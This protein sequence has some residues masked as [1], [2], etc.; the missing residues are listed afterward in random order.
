M[1]VCVLIPSYNEART[2]GR[3]VEKIKKMGIDVI[4][5]DD[6]STDATEKIASENG[7]IVIRHMK[8]VGKGASLKEGFEFI[9]KTTDF[10]GIIIMDG[11]GQHEPD[12][13]RKF[14]SR[15]GDYDDDIIVGNRMMRAEGM[16]FVR[17]ATN[18]FMS[19][20]LSRLC[21]QDIPDTQCGFKFIRRK[22]LEEIK[23][24]SNNY[25]FD[26]EL[27]IRAARRHFKIASVPIRTIY[28]DELSRI[29]PIKDTLKFVGLLIK[30]CSA[31]K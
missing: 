8:N 28:G 11:D 20:L 7:A 16:P 17:R 15:A 12:D 9:L 13:I 3:I 5:V 29:N 10:E 22:I 2:I 30:T 6:G 1:K 18:R 14:I 24:D 23:L 26:S 31:K 4:V 27:L 21:R 25:D 19:R